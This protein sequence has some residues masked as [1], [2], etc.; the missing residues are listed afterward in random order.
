L[1]AKEREMSTPKGIGKI[2]QQLILKVLIDFTATLWF[3][4]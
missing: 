4:S 3:F 2:D 1:A